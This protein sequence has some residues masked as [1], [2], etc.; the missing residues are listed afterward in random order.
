[1]CWRSW[2]WW[3]WIYVGVLR[4]EFSLWKRDET[5]DSNKLKTNSTHRKP[6]KYLRGTW[7]PTDQCV[8]T[9]SI[10]VHGHNQCSSLP[11]PHIPKCRSNDGW[12]PG[13]CGD[14]T[15]TQSAGGGW[16]QGGSGK[17]EI[18][19]PEMASR[20]LKSR[21]IIR[22]TIISSEKSDPTQTHLILW[23]P[24]YGNHSTLRQE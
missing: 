14:G 24:Q 10:Q 6:V 20:N 9:S 11:H 12:W 15:G 18:S 17:A 19:R 22:K 5:D 13:R 7:K 3:T 16:Q 23:S 2:G 1:M 21:E 4:R 8:Q